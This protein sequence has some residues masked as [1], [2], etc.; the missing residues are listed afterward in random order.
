MARRN[1]NKNQNKPKIRKSAAKKRVPKKQVPKKQ[2]GKKIN[3]KASGGS[4]NKNQNKLKI[5]KKAAKK[6]IRK[7]IIKKASDGRLNKKDIKQISKTSY[8][9]I[10][11]NKLKR[12]INRYGKNND[13][14]IN[15]KIDKLIPKFNRKKFSPNKRNDASNTPIYDVSNVAPPGGETDTN[16]YVTPYV[17]PEFEEPEFEEEEEE[18]DYDDPRYRQYV[19]GIRTKRGNR[20][21]QGTRGSFG[22][23]GTRISGMK[24]S[25]INI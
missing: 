18:I 7:K 23:G 14:K 10:G 24:V 3:K 4:I 19:L 1:K 13:L 15:K 2:V 9:R 20:N 17:E 22:R 5:R 6:Q 11:N 8:N 12:I 25:G 16:N 21:R